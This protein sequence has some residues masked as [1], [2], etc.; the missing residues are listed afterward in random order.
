MYRASCT[1]YY[2]HIKSIFYVVKC[3]AFVGLDNKFFFH[4][5][6]CVCVCM[7]MCVCVCV[8]TSYL[9]IKTPAHS[10]SHFLLSLFIT[11]LNSNPFSAAVPQLSVIHLCH[12]L[13]SST[14]QKVS[15]KTLY[16]AV[17]CLQSLGRDRTT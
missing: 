16:W 15:I 6:L 9:S 7:C 10:D 1:V 14:F 8:P 2:I 4:C 11:C 3:R 17:C 12:G 13:P 5:C